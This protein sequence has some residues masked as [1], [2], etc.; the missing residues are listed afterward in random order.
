MQSQNRS[1]V[2]LHAKWA[3]SKAIMVNFPV[4]GQ[5]TG[6]LLDARPNAINMY[7][8]MY[9]Y[10][11]YIIGRNFVELKLGFYKKLGTCTFNMRAIYNAKKWMGDQ[12]TLGRDNME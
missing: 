12:Q 7:V 4:G 9:I 10:T 8:C 6:L 1:K 11:H 2:D 3:K 5:I